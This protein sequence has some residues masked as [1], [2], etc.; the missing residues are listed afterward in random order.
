MSHCPS[1]VGVAIRKMNTLSALGSAFV[2]TLPAV[3]CYP[4]DNPTQ[5]GRDHPC[6][7]LPVPTP[8]VAEGSSTGQRADQRPP[9]SSPSAACPRPPSTTNVDFRL[10]GS[11]EH[12]T[13][14]RQALLYAAR[15]QTFMTLKGG[16]TS[17]RD[18]AWLQTTFYKEL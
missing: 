3:E 7:A 15:R 10:P 14:P 17:P 1:S 8:P 12:S 5:L 13:L 4:R 6:G 11:R 2:Y 9:A 16:S 18:P